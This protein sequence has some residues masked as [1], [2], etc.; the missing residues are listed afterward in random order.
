MDGMVS[1][2]FGGA[3]ATGARPKNPRKGSVG[4][5]RRPSTSG[6]VAST[7]DRKA[8]VYR[9]I[10]DPQSPGTPGGASAAAAHY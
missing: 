4:S 3:S 2:S 7:D 5:A 9:P 10:N 6:S 1:E 8:F